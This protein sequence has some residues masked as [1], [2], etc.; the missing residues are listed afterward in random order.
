MFIDTG[1]FAFHCPSGS[2][3]WKLLNQEHVDDWSC[4]IL[5]NQCVWS[6]G[7]S[8]IC[9]LSVT[10]S[11]SSYSCSYRWLLLIKIVAG[12]KLGPLNPPTPSSYWCGNPIFED[13]EKLTSARKVTYVK[14]SMRDV[15]S[16]SLSF[17][18]FRCTQFSV[19]YLKWFCGWHSIWREENSTKLSEYHFTICT[20]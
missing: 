14:A 6:I 13:P 4:S 11:L 18:C 19:F 12:R 10:R 16:C 8:P 3:S 9:F 17:H 2:R 1:N 7:Y 20:H 5:T 15:E